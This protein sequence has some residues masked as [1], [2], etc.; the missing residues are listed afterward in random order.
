MLR[1]LHGN[2][3]QESR[4]FYFSLRQK[5][6]N[7]LI[8]DGATVSLT[9]LQQALSGSDLFGESQDIFIEDLLSKRKSSKELDSLISLISQTSQNIVLWEGKEL[10]KKLIQLFPK[11]TVKQF[12]FPK[13]IFSFLDSLLPD[14]GKILVQK[15]HEVLKSKDSEFVLF[16]LERQCRILLALRSGE[17]DNSISEITSLAPWQK[18]KLEKQAKQFTEDAL[19]RLHTKLYEIDLGHKTGQLSQSLDDTLDL[20]L[21]SI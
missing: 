11:S 12:D 19:I 3:I 17:G 20:F 18:S 9:D 21:L 1:I 13:V 14:N 16:M 8:F 2:D 6:T 15:F 10:A 5:S 4:D 7:T